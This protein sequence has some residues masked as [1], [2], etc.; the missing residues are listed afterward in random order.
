MKIE[1]YMQVS[2]SLQAPVKYIIWVRK[3]EYIVSKATKSQLE[4][5]SLLKNFCRLP[6]KIKIFYHKLFSRENFQW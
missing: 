4:K 6:K 2:P 3:T 5:Y 1:F